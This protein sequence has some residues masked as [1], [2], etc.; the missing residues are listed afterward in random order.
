MFDCLKSPPVPSSFPCL[1]GTQEHVIHAGNYRHLTKIS[2]KIVSKV[3]S[4]PPKVQ[5]SVAFF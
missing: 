4:N 1:F 5:T 3:F 2:I